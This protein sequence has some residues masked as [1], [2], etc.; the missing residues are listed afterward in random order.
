MSPV[1]PLADETL[2]FGSFH[3]LPGQHLL[4]DAGEPVPVGSRALH[5][6]T[7]LV[8]RP[9]V[10]VSKAE[11]IRR[12]WPDTI[13]DESNLK[14]HVAALRKVLGDGR[15]G[16]RYVVNVPGR[17]YMFVA[18]VVSPKHATAAPPARLPPTAAPALPYRLPS[19]RTRLVGRAETVRTLTGQ[20]TQSRFITIVGPGG[21]GKTS[22]ALAVASVL[23]AL[24]LDGVCFVD[25][26]PVKDPKL[27]ASA[28]A[29][30][31]GVAVRSEDAIPALVAFLRDKAMLVVLD[32]C[33]HVVTA[34]AALSDE[35]FTAL[36]Q[37]HLL[38]TSREPLRV[39]SERVIRLPSLS[40][41]PESD[42]LTS[43]EALTF[44]SVELFIA[45]ASTQLEPYPLSDDDA[46]FV[47]D[48]C[49]R[50]DG[51]A[52]AIEMAAGRVDAF[53]VRGVAALLDDRF[54]MLRSAW[55]DALPR[56]Q[57]LMVALDW[58]YDLL[59]ETER[60]VLRRLGVFAGYFTLN[61][62]T[63]VAA[64]RPLTPADVVSAIASLVNQS[65][66]SADLSG[67]MAQYR[68]LDTTCA[69]A[70]KK[71]WEEGEFGA[72]A[73]RHAKYCH[74]LLF[75]TDLEP[76]AER[77]IDSAAAYVGQVANV[78][79]ALDWAFSPDGDTAAG[80]A[81]TI[82][83][84]P[85][86]LSTSLIDECRKRVKRA[87]ECVMPGHDHSARQEMQLLTAL[88]V[89]MYS[90]GPSP[91]SRN[92]WA[93]VL[94]IAESLGDND[95]RIR[96][97]WGL[98]VV[99]VTGG[100]HREGLQ[101]AENLASL[102][103]HTSD[104]VDLLVGDRL[105]GT[106]LHFLGQQREAKRHFEAMLSRPLSF[107]IRKQIIRYQFD[108]SVVGHAFYSRILWLHGLPDQAMRAVEDSVSAAQA[109]GH[110]LSLCYALG[111]GACPVSLLTGDLDA[112][113]RSVA[114]LTDSAAKHALPLWQSMG[115]CFKGMLL[116]RRGELTTGLRLLRES[117]DELSAAGFALYHT[118]ALIE[119]AQCLGRAGETSLA[120]ATIEQAVMQAHR[121]EEHW[122]EPE[123]LRVKGEL[124]L[125]QAAPGS[126]REAEWHFMT[127]FELAQQQQALSWQLRSATSLARL[128]RDQRRRSDAMRTLAT[129][130]ALFT[131]G[132]ATHDLV[133]AKRLMNEAL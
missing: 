30:S 14:V 83:S 44:S 105:V 131:E 116:A 54:R 11:L 84:V 90:Q 68:L 13:V 76:V 128:Q 20:L 48:I 41:P 3:L 46:P 101:L 25:L 70:R 102:A 82:A 98:W 10:L 49:R 71:L 129:T 36:P 95:Y 4:L 123:I 9:G 35:L 89:V 62:A 63:Q 120:L 117:S 24:F 2:S 110:A 112:A 7:A 38:A 87:L 47:A 60:L 45:R 119:F 33:E 32:S 56:H 59:S 126:E 104:A 51:N 96:A 1:T 97:L 115:R 79:V 37:L 86:W 125:L 130:Y 58:S 50:L 121:H 66:V 31:L 26:A 39:V 57:S 91:E 88:G 100:R 107:T 81:L 99:C 127:S 19:P 77:A 65:L 103:R 73:Q 8:E 67:T 93:K 85:L 113:E 74:E 118:A 42:S 64:E 80:V 108:Q 69:Y 111:Q 21:V 114:L 12:V 34:T 92:A 55:R 122:C 109:Q 28:L 29:T 6:L 23:T 61:A 124:V 72:V 106:S 78:R 5:I 53:G 18:R 132:F 17:G 40:I 15:D 133:V 94:G 43:S 75:Q 52:L 16:R 27:V 22:V